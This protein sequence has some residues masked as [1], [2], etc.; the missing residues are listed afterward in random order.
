MLFPDY[1]VEYAPGRTSTLL[2][3]H[4]GVVGYNETGQTQYYEY[5]RYSPNSPSVIGKRRPSDD[6]NIRRVAIPDLEIGKDGLPTPKSM[7]ALKKALSKKSGKGTPAKLTCDQD[8]DEN[9]VYDEI[10][11]QA[12]DPKRQPYSWTPW[13]A[14]HCRTFANDAYNAGR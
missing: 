4:A 6:G 7:E 2:G 5:G 8:A 1:P 11:N 12:N 13:N 9:K 14:N 10:N 3:G